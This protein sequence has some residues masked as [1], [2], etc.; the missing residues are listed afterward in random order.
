MVHLP[1]HKLDEFKFIGIDP[2][3]ETLGVCITSL[4]PYTSQIT[5]INAFTLVA[6]KTRHFD[7]NLA[8]YQ[9]HK[10]AR[11]SALR[12][13]VMDLIVLHSPI[14]VASEAPFYNMR[15][16][17]AYAPL[18]ET[19]LVIRESLL[20]YNRL[21][22]LLAIDPPTVK[23]A[24]GAKGNADKDEVKKALVKYFKDLKFNNKELENLDEHSID[25]I[26]VCFCALKQYGVL[27]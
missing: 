3:T 25:A 23:K 6:S 21:L 26:C 1:N 11:I 17:N 20:K 8:N 2:G 7:K 14:L 4:C 18:V 13:S 27:K 16:P 19:L 12:D 5:N 10:L 22:P 9:D 24:V 15:R